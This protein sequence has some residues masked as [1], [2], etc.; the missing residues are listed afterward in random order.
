MSNRQ[1]A[2]ADNRRRII[3]SAA[4]LFSQGGY[5]GTGTRDIARGANINE[6]TIFRHFPHKRDLYLAVLESELQKVRLRGDLLAEVAD[7]L[8]ARSALANTYTL[9]T[10]ALAEDRGLLRLLQFSS[11]EF[12]KDIDPLLR[13]HFRELVEVIAVYLQPW[14]DNGQLQCANAKVIVLTFVAIVLNYNSV[15]SV[16][17]EVMP[18]LATTLNVHADVCGTLAARSHAAT[19]ASG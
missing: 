16:F 19:T 10:S 18:G 11:L 9:I 13:K 5:N 1:A 3:E 14:I 8:D 17:S 2:V 15:F 4:K 6:A 12:G 7:A